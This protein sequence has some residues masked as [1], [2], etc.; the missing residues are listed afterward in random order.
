MAVKENNSAQRRFRSSFLTSV[1]SIALVLFL[2]G[3]VGFLIL[4]ANS[5]RKFVKENIA[6]NIELKEGLRDADIQQFRKIVDAKKYTNSTD[7]VSKEEAAMETQ[8]VLGEDFIEFLGYNPLPATIKLKLKAPY[9]NPDSIF[10]LEKEIAEYEQVSDIYY[11]KTLIHEINDNV[12]QISLVITAFSVLL[13]LVALA[14][15]NN[16]IRLRV[17]A[18]RFLIHTMQL[19]GASRGFIRKPFLWT[20]VAHG[21]LASLIAISLLIAVLYI[22]EQQVSEIIYL[23]ELE[24]LGMLFG[25]VIFLGIVISLISTFFAVN[26]YLNISK[27]ELYYR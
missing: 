19:V 5:I 10:Y 12:K 2:L 13:L 20:G 14:L 17:Y 7:F 27:D 26:R 9:A 8:R 21:A 1:L 23:M 11:K 18:K 24:V 3:I 6:V 15:I 16:T 4:N 25:A 22:A